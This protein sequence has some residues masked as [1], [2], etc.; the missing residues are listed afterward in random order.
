MPVTPL[1]T[2]TFNVDHAYGTAG[3]AIQ[4]VEA[5]A[6]LGVDEVHCMIQM[7]T[8]P[9]EVVMETIRQW[10]EYIIPRFR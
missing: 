4:Y 9:N 2:A 10:G 8:I 5:L 6:D 1:T 3:H 7:G